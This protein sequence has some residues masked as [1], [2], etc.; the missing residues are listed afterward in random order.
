MSDPRD[1]SIDPLESE[2]RA[3][4]KA[5]GTPAAPPSL[6][7]ALAR[8]GAEPPSTSPVQMVVSG[9]RT[10]SSGRFAAVAS[11]LVVI[12]VTIA[13]LLVVGQHGPAAPTGSPGLVPSHA[14]SPGPVD[15]QSPPTA[16]AP[17]PID[18]SGIFGSS[19]LWAAV[20][21][22]LYLS[23]DYGAT[24]VQHTLLSGVALDATSGDV[25]S[26]VFVLDTSHVWTASP[27]PGSTV[28][29][30]GQG[31]GYDHLYVVVSRTTDGGVS[32]QSVTIPDDWGGTQPVLAFADAE[33]GFLLLSGL[34]G[35]GGS[36]VFATTDGGA[37]WQRVGGADSLGSIFSASD[38]ATLW[39]GNEGDA[40]PVARPILDVSRDGGRTWADARLPGLVG[41]I[42][43]ND[44]PVA[45]PVFSGQNGAVAVI[46]ASTDNSPMVRFYRSSDGG[47]AWVLAAQVHI[48]ES[49]ST[50]V[51]VV[52][53]L[54][55]VV[56][57]SHTG[58][59]LATSDGG[60]TWQQ[61]AS[62]GLSAALR[63]RFWDV[64]NGAAVVQTTNGPASASGLFRTTDAGQSWTPVSI[65]PQG[66]S[67]TEVPSPAPLPSAGGT[68]SASQFV[69]GTA[70]YDYG[71]GTLGSTVVFVTQ[72]LRNAGGNCVLDL[73]GMIDVAAATGPFHSI[74]VRNAGTA[75]SWK[76]KSGQSLSIVIGGYWWVGVRDGTGRLLGS[77]PPCADPIS[78]VT[79]VEFPLAS[80][81]IQIDLPTI[82]HEVCSS[83]ASVSLTVT[84]QEA[85]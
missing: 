80:G 48:G 61:S 11:A 68:C 13:V 5:S 62:S 78:D 50:G 7:A 17:S 20:G 30:G 18:D 31:P 14:A 74:P 25:L 67:T 26:S 56:I 24:W 9:W 1:Q 28:P 41:D 60:V 40:G 83:P 71:F 8:L 35:G 69:L 76:I 57:D 2:L 64:R 55:Y 84:N 73:P 34:R 29:Y 52:D 53:P 49:G 4:F 10:T 6:N 47:R 54:R 51:A 37:T 58:R 27:G 43:V 81:S 12:M 22:Q 77:V 45:P 16:A 42:F 44:N 82:W 3:W 23:S 66:P 85:P 38:A 46:A 72:P 65:S 75:T 36:V 15:L 63:V 33:H 79:R 32:W 59:F 70:T 19:G 21:G 39:A